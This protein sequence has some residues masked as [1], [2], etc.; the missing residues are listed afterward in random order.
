MTPHQKI[1]VLK[2]LEDA[3]ESINKMPTTTPCTLCVHFDFGACKLWKDAIPATFLEKG[4]DKWTFDK[5][6]PPF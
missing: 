2:H 3:W 5:N 6:S 1:S 4:C